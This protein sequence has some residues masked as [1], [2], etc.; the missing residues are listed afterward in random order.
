MKKILLTSILAVI[1]GT[2]IVNADND[3]TVTS[4]NYVDTQIGTRQ[5]KITAGTTGNVVLYNGTSN[6]GQTQF[7]GR[8]VYDGANDYNSSTD[9]NKL[10]TAGAVDGMVGDVYDYVDDEISNIPTPELPTGTADTVVMYDSNGE[11]GGEREINNISFFGSDGGAFADNNPDALVTV[12]NLSE[13][14][15]Q[16]LSSNGDYT[17]S[18]NIP[19]AVAVVGFAQPKKVCAG[20]PDGTTTPD[21]THTDA[22]CVLW[23]LPY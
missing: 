13:S 14:I 7:T 16:S 4:K 18:R 17:G 8:A 19:T 1:V 23:D 2:T 20:W 3:K 12:G 6:D 9:S 21:P 5:E 15:V 22:N 11:I 10:I